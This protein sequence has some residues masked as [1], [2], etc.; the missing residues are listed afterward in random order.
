MILFNHGNQVFE[1]TVGQRIAQL[2]LEKIAEDVTVS[3][4]ASLDHL[5]QS[6]RGENGFGSTDKPTRGLVGF[7]VHHESKYTPV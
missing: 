2:L 3:Q 5:G 7:G 6:V 1:V 4:V